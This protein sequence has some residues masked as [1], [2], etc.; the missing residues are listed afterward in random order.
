MKKPA[1]HRPSCALTCHTTAAKRNLMEP[2]LC[3][4]CGH[5]NPPEVEKC[6]LCQHHLYVF[7]HCGVRNRRADLQCRECGGRLR[8]IHRRP[9]TPF[10][11]VREHSRSS[12]DL[13]VAL[14]MVGLVVA[15]F[16]GVAFGPGIKAWG[17]A[18]REAAEDRENE[19][20]QQHESE[21]ARQM[22]AI[23]RALE[24]ERERQTPLR[25]WIEAH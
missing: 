19:I 13:M 14:V 4:R 18:K 17:D 21:R 1:L 6:G 15:L 9:M 25:K 22:Q 24:Q 16:A 20:R 5:T 10:A 8:V 23:H 11:P 3:H 2:T 7:C 12:G